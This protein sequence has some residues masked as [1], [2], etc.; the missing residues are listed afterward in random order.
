MN[1][2]PMKTLMLAGLS[3]LSLGLG[4][5]MAQEGGSIYPAVP[6][7]RAPK[8]ARPAEAVQI[9]SGTSDLDAPMNWRDLPTYGGQG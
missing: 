8:A 7:Y 5:A 4:T 1:M 6:S 9:Q 2:N 3:A